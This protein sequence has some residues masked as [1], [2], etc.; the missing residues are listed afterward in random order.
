MPAAP[1]LPEETRRRIAELTLEEKA[2]L[3]LGSDIWHTAA[4]ESGSR[5]RRSR[6]RTGRTACGA[7][8]TEATMSASAARCLRPASR[9][10]PRSAPRGTRR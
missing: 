5:P 4:V 3:V 2:S 6:C 8:P 1:D 9:R 10:P 7:S